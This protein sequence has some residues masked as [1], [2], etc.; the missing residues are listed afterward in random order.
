M[1]HLAADGMRYVQALSAASGVWQGVDA[2]VFPPATL[3]MLLNRMLSGTSIQLGAQNCFPAARG[4]FTGELSPAQVLDAGARWLLVGHSE[5]RTVLGETDEVVAK[6]LRA[7]VEAG[8]LVMLC[9]GEQEEERQGSRME[10][11]LERQCLALAG[12]TPEEARHVSL[13]YEP[14][15]AIGTGNVATPLEAQEAH[16]FLRERVARLL[17]LEI[18][19]AMRIV[20]GGS[21]TPQSFP[22]LLEQQD[23]DGGLVGG[24][25]LDADRFIELVR[26]ASG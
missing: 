3:L 26:Q 6:K 8:L 10:E 24:A 5:R 9:V 18:A 20:Y 15:W 11:V 25:S 4:A 12:L 14:V 19:R 21:I 22:S 13:A 17:G 23:V 2:V 1:N 16:A 7:G